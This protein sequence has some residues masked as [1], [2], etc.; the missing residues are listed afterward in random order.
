[1]VVGSQRAAATML[2]GWRLEA[3]RAACLG[4][5]VLTLGL[6]AAGFAAGFRDPELI[7]QPTIRTVLVSAGVPLRLTI[8][9]GLLVPT[10]VSAVTAAVLFWR[11]FDDWMALLF[12]LFLVLFGSF[13]SRALY[14]LHAAHPGARPL[15]GFV[16]VA[17]LVVGILLLSVFPDGRFVPGWTR[18]LM[19][20]VIPAFASMPDMLTTVQRLPDPLGVPAWR[21]GVLPGCACG[22]RRA[23]D[24]RA[25][26]ALLARVRPRP[27]AAGEVGAVRIRGLRAGAAGWFCDPEP[28][29]QHRQPVVCVGAGRH[30]RL[31][32]AVPGL[33]R[34][35]DVALPAV[36]H[37]P[38]HQP[39][40]GLRAAHRDL[41]DQLR[42]D[43]AGARPA[44][45][46]HRQRHPQPRDRQCDLGRGGAVSA[47]APAGAGYGRPDALT[48]EL[49]EIVDQTMQP[50][51]LSL[52]L[53]PTRNT[54]PGKTR[55]AY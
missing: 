12:G 14:A 23:W 26:L 46:H 43:R 9:I 10:V 21:G 8:A 36:C 29:R 13:E 34:G 25:G 37:R 30:A 44:R 51:R 42:A 11:R 24:R 49:L 28:V 6:V 1:M 41:G 39:D 52:W 35:G 22:Q 15:I 53:R 16:S 55:S 33:G 48:H 50:T 27:A 18:L 17:T 5:A 45:R 19:L 2:R 3:A 47:A 38:D 40:A 54:P 20:A 4:V 32:R 31:Q 7:S